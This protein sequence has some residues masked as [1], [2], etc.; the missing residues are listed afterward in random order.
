MKPIAL[1]FARLNALSIFPLVDVMTEIPQKQVGR[2]EV[3]QEQRDADRAL[4][5]KVRAQAELDEALR[6]AVQHGHLEDAKRLI[7]Q[8]ASV[9]PDKQGQTPLSIA[10][11]HGQLECVRMLL[12]LC[13]AQSVSRISGFAPLGDAMM[14][15][16]EACFDEL[17]PVSDTKVFNEREM[18]WSNKTPGASRQTMLMWAAMNKGSGWGED[19][20]KSVFWVKKI[21]ALTPTS[22]KE[23]DS[24]GKTALMFAVERAGGG[25]EC[26]RALLPSS[27][28][29]QQDNL[30]KTAL[31]LAVESAV[32]NDASVECVQLLLAASDASL[33]DKKG[34]TALMHAAALGALNLVEILA[35][36]TDCSLLDKNGKTALMHAATHGARPVQALL[37]FSDASARDKKGNT[38][39]LIAIQLKKEGAVSV[40]APKTDCSIR[41]DR[42]L[43]ALGEALDTKKW[44]LAEVVS[45]FASDSDLLENAEKIVE[46]GH[47]NLPKTTHRHEAAVLRTEVREVKARQDAELGEDATAT[48]SRPKASLRI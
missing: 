8:G 1:W 16:H 28:A 10:A 15:D 42:G 17:L 34:R 29:N 37:A 46:A 47:K 27:D 11:R 39:L 25:E 6:G 13:D 40:L 21:L 20:G 33:Q 26:V 14:G 19:L 22:A 24:Q 2:R 12:P 38:A 31:M 32:R 44:R 35:P 45:V 30:G 41:G 23:G 18:A 43:T 48:G 7:A 5:L 36:K 9:A 4:T 3:S